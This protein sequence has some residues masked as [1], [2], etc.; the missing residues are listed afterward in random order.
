MLALF[1]LVHIVVHL[2]EEAVDGFLAA[3][4]GGSYGK[5]QL[6]W[7]SVGAVELVQLISQ[8]VLHVNEV[9]FAVNSGDYD[10]LV[11][12]ESYGKAL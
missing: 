2:V 7:S 5:R 8:T 4:D 10:E 6:I 9:E 1:L 3:E 11:T 12:C